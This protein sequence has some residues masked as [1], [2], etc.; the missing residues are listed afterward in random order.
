MNAPRARGDPPPD[1][2]PACWS[3]HEAGWR[4]SRYRLANAPRSVTET[5]RRV[6]QISVTHIGIDRH[7]RKPNLA[8]PHGAAHRLKHQRMGE[9]GTA[10]VLAAAPAGVADALCP[11]ALDQSPAAV[12]GTSAQ[13]SP[14]GDRYC[15]RTCAA[16][17]DT[18][19]CRPLSA[20]PAEPARPRYHAARHASPGSA[21]SRAV[22]SHYGRA[23]GGVAHPASPAVFLGGDRSARLRALCVSD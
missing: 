5:E 7:K 6:G 11:F 18:P 23:A 3:V 12:A 21:E 17:R 15:S 1:G 8:A 13:P 22:R 20:L 10:G 19:R 4:K 16:R 2:G 14:Q 9:G